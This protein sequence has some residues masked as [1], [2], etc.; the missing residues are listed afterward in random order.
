MKYSYW[1][2]IQPFTFGVMPFMW[3]C[4]CGWV[5][6]IL[7]WLRLRHTRE[8]RN[9]SEGAGGRPVVLPSSDPKH[10][11][12]TIFKKEKKKLIL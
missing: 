1:F 3:I 9:G 12:F 11:V 6:G 4:G 2:A 10:L 8:D 7:P 5:L